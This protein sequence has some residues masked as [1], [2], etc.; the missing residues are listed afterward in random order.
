MPLVDPRQNALLALLPA[1]VMQRLEQDLTVISGAAGDVLL[2][3]GQPINDVYFPLDLVVSLDQPVTDDIGDAAAAPG[4]AL[5]GREGAIGIEPFLGAETSISRATVRV[6]GR[7]LRLSAATL[8]AEF[9]R[10]GAFQRLLLRSADALLAQVSAIA[11]C[12]RVH[13]IQQRL[14]RWLL[15][16]DDRA[17]RGGIGL[18]QESLSELLG[19]RRASISAA[20]SQLQSAE[21]IAYRRG[22]I[23]I[24]D[25]IR[26]EGLSCKCYREIKARYKGYLSAG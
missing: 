4:V 20:A 3:P 24:L 5:T 15:L 10:A 17:L 8:R 23:M 6:E 2:Q 9:A 7:A 21:L 26:L 25:R 16:C 1:S 22:N 14:I 11:A 13:P 19:V 18:T 12:E